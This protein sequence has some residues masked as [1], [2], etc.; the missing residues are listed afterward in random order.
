M[1]FILG[2]LVGYSIRGK[3]RLLIATLTAIAVGCFIVLPAIA[4]SLLALDVRRER[5]SRPPQTTVPVVIG[6][7][8][9]AAEMKLR[10]AN[11]NIRVLASRHDL[12][13]E[14]GLIIDQTPR[15]GERVDCG[16]VVGVTV[17][18]K[19]SGRKQFSY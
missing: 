12:P 10:D 11:L 3:Q 19:E 4:L 13:L 2:L 5:L 1:R 16:T 7:N 6:L 9:K 15:G 17:S 8:Y 18:G 14:P